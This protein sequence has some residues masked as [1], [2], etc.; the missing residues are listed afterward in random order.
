MKHDMLIQWNI[1]HSKKG[2]KNWFMLWQWM[3][4]ENIVLLTEK[5]TYCV[6]PLMWN[7]KNSQIY[8]DRKKV[9]DCQDLQREGNGEWLLM[10]MGML[11]GVIEN[12]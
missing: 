11:W 10:G 7:V 5:V 1:I 8:G 2:M 4:L 9:S 3:D 6:T 12:V